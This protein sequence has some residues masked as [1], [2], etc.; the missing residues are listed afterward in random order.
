MRKQRVFAAEPDPL[1][2]TAQ[3][4]SSR[5]P[6]FQWTWRPHVI[7]PWIIL[8]SSLDHP[9][10]RCVIVPITANARWSACIALKWS[11]V[12]RYKKTIVSALTL[13]HTSTWTVPNSAG[14]RSTSVERV[15]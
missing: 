4:G 6:S 1:T 15:R 13:G 8:G 14:S 5:I 12:R 3:G 9:F 7:R 10:E 11:P 2:R